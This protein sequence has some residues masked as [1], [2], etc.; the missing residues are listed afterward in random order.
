CSLRRAIARQAFLGGSS[1]RAG[2]S[3]MTDARKAALHAALAHFAAPRHA[4]AAGRHA[5]AQAALEALIAQHGDDADTLLLLATLRLATD[6]DAAEALLR[7]CVAL[8]PGKAHAWHYLGKA[9]EQRGD[10]TAAIELLGHAAALNP[11]FAPTHNDLGALLQQS[12][13]R[14][15]ALAALDRAIAIDPDYTPAHHNR[16]MLLAE[17]RRPVEARESFRKVLAARQD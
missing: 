14:E 3:G 1:H 15:A 9:A 5:E 17:M 4:E 11:R 2:A 8:A 12:G 16:G 7:R 6:V 13:E 10:L